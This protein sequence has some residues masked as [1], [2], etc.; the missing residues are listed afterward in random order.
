M[1]GI[2]IVN[3]EGPADNGFVINE[4]M[5]RDEAI[6]EMKSLLSAGILT[7]SNSHYLID[8]SIVVN[9]YGEIR[10]QPQHRSGIY[11]ATGS[12]LTEEVWAK[13]RRRINEFDM[14]MHVNKSTK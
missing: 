13:G 8:G 2:L 14:V 4:K 7:Q 9:L 5:T 1:N 12:F 6:A 11:R 3:V 10:N